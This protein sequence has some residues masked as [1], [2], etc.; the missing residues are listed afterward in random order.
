MINRAL[1]P[2]FRSKT[3]E[4]LFNKGEVWPWF[5]LK[6]VLLVY[7]VFFTANLKYSLRLA[8]VKN[9]KGTYSYCNL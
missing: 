4:N 5:S 9:V 7:L 3:F 2:S 8:K 6:A 1:R